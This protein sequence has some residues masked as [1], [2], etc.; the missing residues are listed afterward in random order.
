[1]HIPEA[2][3]SPISMSSFGFGCHPARLAVAWHPSDSMVAVK[4]TMAKA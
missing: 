3:P 1:M 2:I 4:R